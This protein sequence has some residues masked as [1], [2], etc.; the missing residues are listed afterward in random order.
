MKI[1]PVGAELLNAADGRTDIKKIMVGF[2]N[3]ANGSAKGDSVRSALCRVRLGKSSG[4]LCTGGCVTW[5][6]VHCVGLG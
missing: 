4:Q 2:H 3:S 5:W 1:R 6:G